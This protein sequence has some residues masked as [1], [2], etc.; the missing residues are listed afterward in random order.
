MGVFDDREKAQENKYFRDQ[1]LRFKA[2][3]RR[4][5]LYGLWVAG[6]LGLKGKEAEAYALD[7]IKADFQEAGDGDV[8]RKVGG[9]LKAKGKAFPDAELKKQLDACLKE[10]IKQLE[11]EKK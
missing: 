5:K 8:L 9:D 7:V 1:D 10:A 6:Q 2:V 3:A 4:N 11:A